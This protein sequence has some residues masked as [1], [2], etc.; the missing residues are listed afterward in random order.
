MAVESS[1]S[2]RV[3]VHLDGLLPELE[4][5]YKDR[6]PQLILAIQEGNQGEIEAFK[7]RLTANTG[8]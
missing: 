1:P 6:M 3:L 7:K 2:E 4:T 8:G 5:I